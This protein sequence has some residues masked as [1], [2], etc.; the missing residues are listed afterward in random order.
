MSKL[1]LSE[2][3]A[4]TRAAEQV[5]EGGLGT[6]IV[7]VLFEVRGLYELSTPP[8]KSEGPM[9]ILRS[10]KLIEGAGAGMFFGI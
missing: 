7:G 1:E 2:G 4:P 3:L 9:L 10:L 6:L 8:P 5:V